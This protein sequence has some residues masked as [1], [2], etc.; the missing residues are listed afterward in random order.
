LSGVSDGGMNP[1]VETSWR[2]VSKIGRSGQ[3]YQSYRD[4]SIPG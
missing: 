4:L 2:C 1:N 3:W